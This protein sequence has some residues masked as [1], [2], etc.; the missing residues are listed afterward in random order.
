MFTQGLLSLTQRI[1]K[2]N[3]GLLSGTVRGVFQDDWQTHLG[4][5]RLLLVRF[6]YSQAES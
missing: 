1:R 5:L 4:C 3:R 2:Q 6:G